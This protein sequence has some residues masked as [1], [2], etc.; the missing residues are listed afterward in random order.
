M[1]TIVA[2]DVPLSGSVAPPPENN[3][4]VEPRIWIGIWAVAVPA[5]AVT[6]AVRFAKL[7]VPDLKVNVV[8]P[9]APVV[10]VDELTMPVSVDK[11]TMTPGTAA[12]AALSAVMVIVVVPELSE[13]TV[14][15][16]AASV[17]VVATAEVEVGVVTPLPPQLASKAVIAANIKAV[18]VLA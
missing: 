2:G 4:S 9:S 16:E 17:M 8:V 3:E 12:L 1:K 5:A 15:G 11:V 14:V 7:V 10:A 18:K 13:G 6:V